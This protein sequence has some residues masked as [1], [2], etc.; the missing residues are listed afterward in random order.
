V[1]T[2]YTFSV[3]AVYTVS[4]LA[5]YT[6][7]MMTLSLCWPVMYCVFRYFVKQ[8]RNSGGNVEQ[9][10]FLEMFKAIQSRLNKNYEMG[11]T[12]RDIS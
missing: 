3:V 5:V 4:V 8:T 12:H 1:L 10:I 7:C 9:N 11:E 2:V 6:T